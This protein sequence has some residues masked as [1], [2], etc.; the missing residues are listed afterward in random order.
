[1]DIPLNKFG[2]HDPLGRMYVL[3]DMVSAVRSQEAS[4]Q[5]STGLAEDPIQPLVI[6]AN[7]G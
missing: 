6:R 7:E 3:K 4:Q 2:D 1:M 5:V